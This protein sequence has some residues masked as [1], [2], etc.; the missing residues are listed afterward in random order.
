MNIRITERQYELIDA[1]LEREESDLYNLAD[2]VSQ[3]RQNEI[4]EL[5]AMLYEA[6]EDI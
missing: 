2:E 3:R 4:E 6:S 5:R 1:A